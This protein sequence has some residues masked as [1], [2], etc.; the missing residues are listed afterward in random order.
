VEDIAYSLMGLFGVN[1]PTLYG[2]R[3]NAFLRLQLEILRISDDES[4]FAW[5]LDANYPGSGSGLLAPDPAAF[6]SS[7]DVRKMKFDRDRP[8][9]SMTNKGL[10]I[11]PLLISARNIPS[12]SASYKPTRNMPSAHDNSKRKLNCYLMP[13]NCGRGKK[14]RHLAVYLSEGAD[15]QFCR[16]FSHELF[17]MTKSDENGANLKRVP[18]YV[19]Q[20]NY[21]SSTTQTSHFSLA[22]DYPSRK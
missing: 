20:L 21:P 17:Q 5:S 11:E 10:R 3:E 1:M 8:S 16:E 15:G 6:A 2:E 7:G 18:I 12:I 4:I 13:L 14:D 22:T 19:R 9:Y